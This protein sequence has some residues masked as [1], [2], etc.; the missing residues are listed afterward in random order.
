[1]VLASLS[2]MS[3]QIILAA[4][5]NPIMTSYYNAPWSIGVSALYLQP[6]LGGNGLGYSS[7]GNYDGKD[8]NG[9]F[10]G[11]SGAPNRIYNINPKR[12]W[13]FELEGAYRF[14]M[15]HDVNI[16]WYHLNENTSGYLPTGSVFSGNDDGFYAGHLQVA[17]YWNAIHLEVGRRIPFDEN[18]IIRLHAGLS[19]ANINN[20]I[21]NNPQL[22]PTGTVL[23]T[24]KDTMSYNGI[25]PRFG[26]DFGYS[27]GHG[28]DLYAKAAGAVLVGSASQKITGF[29]N[30]TNTIYGFQPYGTPNY[31]QSHSGVIVPEVEAKLGVTYNYQIAPNNII[32]V[33]LGYLWLSYINAV[34]S[35]TNVGIVGTADGASIGVNTT[36]NFDLNGLYL[37][38]NWN[39]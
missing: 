39:V 16:Q 8:D 7:F 4:S 12:G 9:V 13:G 14:S 11:V 36:T 32:S 21:T 10:V 5:T 30:Y 37:G 22:Y 26:G 35:Y 23:F 28:L 24:T 1:M 29:Q 18:K 27:V 3:S 33:D 17:Q 19:F 25:G 31:S 15:K 34:K 6:S 20:E 2:V 38:I